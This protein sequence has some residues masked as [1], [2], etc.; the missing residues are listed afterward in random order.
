[1]RVLAVSLLAL[2]VTACGSRSRS[3]DEISGLESRRSLPTPERTLPAAAASGDA[4]APTEAPPALPRMESLD[5]FGEGD[6]IADL[7][8]VRVADRILLAWITYSD[9]TPLPV[10]APKATRARGAAHAPPPPPSKQGASVMVRALDKAAEPVG[11]PTVIS[12]KA[13]SVGGVALA[14]NSREDVALAWVGKDGGVGQVFLTQLSATGEKLT[15]RMLTHSKGGCSDVTLA[16][17]TS[18]W[19]V[20]WIDSHEGGADV[21]VAKVG[22][23]LVRVGAE[24]R[25]AQ[26]KGEA[27]ELH[28]LAR[29]DEVLLAWNEVRT[30]AALSGILAARLTGADLTVRGDPVRV[31]QATPHARGLDLAPLADGVVLAWIED[32][33]P[34]NRETPVKRMVTLVRLDPSLRLVAEPV[35]PSLASDPSSIALDCDQTCRVVVPSADQEQLLFY[36]FA[37]D[38]GRS[39]DRPARLTVIPGAST[40]DVS[41]VLVRDWLF[42]AEDNLHGVGRLRRAKIIWR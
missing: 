32:G 41:P 16:A 5:A 1:M 23:D 10:P 4:G 15:Q 19:L 21:N 18:G 20:A 33:P 17:T 8:A 13:E 25:I 38:G 31:V 37:Y 36:G 2:A 9:P 35:H 3:A 30:D 7:T 11:P 12:A 6:R 22:K 34:G 27:S 42:F 39:A 29:G 14:A 40:E 26:S 24:H 28:L